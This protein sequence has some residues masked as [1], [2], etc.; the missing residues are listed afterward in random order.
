M[1]IPCHP[2]IHFP[3]ATPEPDH[4]CSIVMMSSVIWFASSLKHWPG[5]SYYFDP[6]SKII[7]PFPLD[8]L[9]VREAVVG[10]DLSHEETPPALF[11]PENLWC[12]FYIRRVEPAGLIHFFGTVA[13]HELLDGNEWTYVQPMIRT[14]R[15]RRPGRSVDN[16]VSVE[17]SLWDWYARVFLGRK[18][19]LGRPPLE[20]HREQWQD[21]F[22]TALDKVRKREAWT[23]PLVANELGISPSGVKNRIRRGIYPPKD[24]WNA[25]YESRDSAEAP[26]WDW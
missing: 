7:Y 2:Y 8:M 16:V 15:C 25:F 20:R 9:S 17:K 18:T 4:V 14:D 1:D 19:S 22:W 21:K 10:Y 11:L 26:P 5:P 13:R 6:D 23:F 3:K 24:L 12:T